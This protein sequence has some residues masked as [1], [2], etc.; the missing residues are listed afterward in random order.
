MPY[1]PCHYLYISFIYY[2]CWVPTISVL[3]LAIFPCYSNLLLKKRRWAGILWWRVLGYVLPQLL[4][5]YGLLDRPQIGFYI[6]G[7]LGDFLGDTWHFCRAHWRKSKSS[8]S[9]T[10]SFK[11]KTECVPLSVP[12]SSFT[13][14]G[15]SSEINSIT[16]VYYIVSYYKNL[17]QVQNGLSNGKDTNLAQA[18]D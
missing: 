9:V 16:S 1:L 18:D 15:T 2:T 10:P 7:V 17:L 13:H 11:A 3:N 14:K 8:L 4:F 5:L 6:E 12:G